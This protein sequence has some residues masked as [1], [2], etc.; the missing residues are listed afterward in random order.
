LIGSGVW[1][2]SLS[3]DLE[4]F[5]GGHLLANAVWPLDRNTP[6]NHRPLMSFTQIACI[7]CFLGRSP[8]RFWTKVSGMSV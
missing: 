1:L 4:C 2:P 5:F 6:E 7:L 3:S 8:A